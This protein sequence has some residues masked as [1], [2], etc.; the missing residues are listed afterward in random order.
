MMTSSSDELLSKG[1][2]A[3][4]QHR[5]SAR[6][7]RQTPSAAR[8]FGADRAG[9]HHRPARSVRL[10]QDHADALHRRHPDRDR[11]APSRCSASRPVRAAL[12]RRVGYL[13]QDPTIYNDLRI[14][15]NVRYFASL[16]GFDDQA[17][18][19]AI[20]RVGLTDHRTALLRQPLRRS[21]HPGVAGVRAGLPTRAARA[22]RAHGGPGPGAAR[23]SL[24]AVRPT[25]PAAR[26]H[27]AGVQPR[28]GR[29]R[30]LRRP[31][32]DARWP[33]RRA[34]HARPDYERTPDARHW[35]TRFC[36]SSSAA[37]CAKPAR[38]AGTT[39]AT[40]T[41]ILRQLAADHRSVAMILFVPILV[42]TLMY[43]MF[44]MRR[45]ARARRAVQQRLPDP[46]G[47]FPAFRDVHHHGDHDA[48]GTG[49]RDAGA[50]PDHSA[51]PARPA[52]RLRHR[53][54]D[55]RCGAGHFG[56]HRV[57]LVA[58]LRHRRQPGVGVRDRDRQRRARCR[59][60]PA[61]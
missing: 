30:P 37:P 19:A 23:R 8:L 39:R 33:P 41:R 49:L 13:P 18:D 27:A 47:P 50:H 17:A 60:G 55:R 15:D 14:V 32:A 31:V 10:R 48:A 5:A 40:T 28:D 2:R 57:V 24:G 46:A 43:F 56:V 36:P 29:G 38:A 44:R 6:G 42:I 25:S 59:P 7:P 4:R 20:E 61:V 1:A 22:R 12:R 52:D 11:R 54:L 35:R 58:R 45:T 9:H 51:A 53:V 34:H 3:G 16:Y 26:Y 21:A